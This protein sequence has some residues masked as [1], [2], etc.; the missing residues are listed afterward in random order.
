MVLIRMLPPDNN[1]ITTVVN[2]RSYSTTASAPVDVP[3]MDALVLR[4]NGWHLSALGGVGTT[5][6]RPTNPT[7]N[8]RFADTTLGV[9]ITYDGKN[10]RNAITGAI[11]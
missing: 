8:M 5:S 7:K 11:V 1:P 4:A 9:E 6:I 3:D 2:G 10:W